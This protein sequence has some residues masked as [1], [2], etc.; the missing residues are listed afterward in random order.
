MPTELLETNLN[1]LVPLSG[2]GRIGIYVDALCGGIEVLIELP[3]DEVIDTRDIAPLFENMLWCLERCC[4][5]HDRPATECRAGEDQHAQIGCRQ[6]RPVEEHLA[7]RWS[8]VVMEVAL[9]SIAALLDDD[10]VEPG[11]REAGGDATSTSS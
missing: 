3:R 5:V 4:V 2:G 10:D 1:D 11:L 6:G 8:L 9:V 7:H